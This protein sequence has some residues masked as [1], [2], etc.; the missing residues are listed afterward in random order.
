MTSIWE[1]QPLQEALK[2]GSQLLLGNA[3]AGARNFVFGWGVVNMGPR[4]EAA[5]WGEVRGV[6]PS[7][8]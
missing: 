1:K 8:E 7:K 5:S 6:T 2:E 4:D 3:T